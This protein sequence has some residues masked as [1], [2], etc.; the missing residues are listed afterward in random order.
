MYRMSWLLVLASVAS[1]SAQ[2]P[3]TPSNEPLALV[4]ANVV[5]VRDGRVTPNATLVLRDGKIA[6][7]GSGAAPSGVRVLDLK[8]KYV[9]PG[10]ID[11]HTHADNFAAFRRALESGVTTVRSAGVSNWAD[12]GFHELVKSGAVV[13]PDVVT[14]GY[15]VRPQIAQEAFLSDPA[16]A[17]LM[18]GVTTIAAMR[19]AVQMSLSHHVDWIKILATERAGTADT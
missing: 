6:S 8:G 18:S 5:N 7:I 13:G 12:V 15:H 1:L 19:R 2:R 17:D 16:Y 3:T 11:A 4:N 9:L 10:L 14:A